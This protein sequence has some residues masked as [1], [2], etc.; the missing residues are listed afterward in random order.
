MQP[1]HFLSLFDLAAE[2][3]RHLLERAMVLKT[4]RRRGDLQA[5][6]ERRVLGMIFEKSSTRTR[7]SFEAGMTQLGGNAIFLAPRDTQLGRGEPISD[8]ARVV[9]SMVDI[10]MIRTFEHASLEHFARYSAVPVINGLTD[11]NHPCQLL[12]DMQ[13]YHEQRGDIRGRTA[14]WIGDGNNMCNSYIEA[15]AQFDFQLRL[16]VPEG[17]EPD[18]GLLQQHG[19]RIELLR[20]PFA[21][22]RGADLVTTDTWA[23]MGQEDEKQERERLF[24]PFQVTSEVMAAA[25]P[26]AIFLHC[27]PA[28]RGQE[29]TGEVIDGPQSRVWEQAEN[30]MHAQKAL[31]EFLLE[32]G[33]A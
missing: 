5:S 21:A 8:T 24:D 2:E 30:R 22:A 18:A 27:L 23:S 14:A 7:V 11:Y 28:Y 26:E 32:V 9:S 13:T 33:A 25:K 1:R 3:A 29:V 6:L 17:F 16:A 10:I 4:M 12:A 31:L 20:D 19:N 15:A